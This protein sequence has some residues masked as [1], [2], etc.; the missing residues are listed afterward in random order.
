MKRP[1]GKTKFLMVQGTGSHV[2]KSLLVAA[3][4]RIFSNRG[5]GVAPFK[6]QNMALNSAV[7]AAGEEV[8]RSIAVQARA[9]RA[10]LQVE[11]NPVLLKPKSDTMAQMILLGK[12]YADLS[13]MAQFRI[14]P[15]AKDYDLAG[16]V[17]I[18][19]GAQDHGAP[20]GDRNGNHGVPFKIGPQAK[21]YGVP[22]GEAS[23]LKEVKLGA[24]RRSLA[25]LSR[26]FERVVIE[27]AGSPAEVNLRE[28]DVVNMAVAEMVDAP[29]LLVADI[30]RG[31]AIA[32]LIGTWTL[33]TDGERRRIKGFIINK[34]RGDPRLLAPALTFLQEKTGIPTV[35]VIPY[36]SGLSLMEEDTLASRSI[37]CGEP[38][39]EIAVV[40]HRHLSNFTDLDPLAV[41][42][43]VTIRYIRTPAQMGSPDAVILPGTKNTVG[44]L[45]HHAESGLA[46]RIQKLA[47]EGVPVVGLCGGYQMMGKVLLD[48]DH[49][50]SDHGDIE[51]LNLLEVSTQF[52][53]GKIVKQA[54]VRPS[55][56]GPFLQ[57]SDLAIQGYE[58]HSGETAP[59]H[60]KV[61]PAFY[62]LAQGNVLE[63]EGATTRSG[64]IFGTSVHGIFEEDRFRRQFVNVLRARKG[65]PLLTGPIVNYAQI[66]DAEIGRWARHVEDHL[67]WPVLEKLF[68]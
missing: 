43:G 48:P 4:C 2:G 42:P 36:D 34:F 39:I 16:V 20:L 68:I 33:L 45:R 5:F 15:Q 41:E 40:E 25:T 10:A 19:P 21:D 67:D 57:E 59:L 60:E 7:T 58:I 50:E 31:G 37:G 28:W 9:A 54:G 11:M 12:P 17:E 35:G 3:L 51:G 30:D 46:G 27:G 56:Q 8:G 29:V 52:R 13:A 14:G 6:A 55:G 32:A 49:L 63:G 62:R 38:E 47:G 22:F 66:Q 1:D 18:S 26:S 61:F 65:L 23:S 53:P 64:L 24:I 44:D